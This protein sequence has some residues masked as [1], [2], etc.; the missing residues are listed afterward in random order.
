MANIRATQSGNFSSSSTWL[1][2]V[3][4]TAGDNVYSNTYTVTIDTNIIC[5]KIS[6]IAENS[7]TAGGKFVVSSNV[8]INANVQVGATV[9][10]EVANNSSP[11]INGNVTGGTAALGRAID[12]LGTGTLSVS[13]TVTGGNISLTTTN[14]T[15]IQHAEAIRNS[16]SGTISLTGNV[17]GGLLAFCAGIVNVLDGNIIINGNVFGSNASSSAYTIRQS[18]TFSSYG[19]ITVNGNVYG[20]TG[21]AISFPT[22]SQGDLTIN[23][24]CYGASNSGVG[25]AL[26]LASVA[27][28]VNIYGNVEGGSGSATSQSG[29]V[30]AG[31]SDVSVNIVGNC[32]GGRSTY[33]TSN[34]TTKHAVNLTGSNSVNITGDVA[35]G[36]SSSTNNWTVATT[37]YG[38]NITG[39]AIVSVTG[40]VDVKNSTSN[41][42]ISL[43]NSSA[44]LNFTGNSYDTHPD[45]NVTNITNITNT[46]GTLN[47]TGN[48]YGK[49]QNFASPTAE[50]NYSISQTSVNSSTTV[51]GNVYGGLTGCGIRALAGDVYIKKVIGN[52]YGITAVA[53]AQRDAVAAFTV[54]TNARFIVEEIEVGSQG[55]FPIFGPLFLNKTTNNVKMTF[56]DPDDYNISRTL[57][58]ATSATNLYPLSSDVRYGISYAGGNLT[59]SCYVPSPSAVTYSVPVDD[60]TGQAVLSINDLLN[61]N[62]EDAGSNSIWKRLKNCSTVSSTGGQLAALV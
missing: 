39:P 31:G 45:D 3:V 60:T 50:S 43:N 23:G 26:S 36:P 46:A 58:D 41:M 37:T 21:T 13:G 28:E 17:N 53:G 52:D 25:V 59:G 5:A 32:T 2:G 9:C 47:I 15:N 24:N 20:S 14:N 44:I 27:G 7:A 29:I 18:N 62:V 8:T 6:N 49:D 33:L 1:G 40:D 34:L 57:I 4:P 11:I 30:L 56:K 16:S 54:G 19:L 35:G 42:A 22:S 12:N 51:V 48:V 10:L 61:F 55:N 38:L